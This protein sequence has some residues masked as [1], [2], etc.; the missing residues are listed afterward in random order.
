MALLSSLPLLLFVVL[1][2]HGVGTSVEL[3]AGGDPNVA[4]CPLVAG[5]DAK[6]QSVP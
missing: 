3:V 1:A 2:E 5:R 4:D 6:S